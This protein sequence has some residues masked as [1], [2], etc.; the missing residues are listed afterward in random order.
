MDFFNGYNDNKFSCSPRPKRYFEIK[1]CERGEWK[2]FKRYHYLNTEISKA[3][4]CYGLYDKENDE[5]IGFIGILHTPHPVNKKL[6]RVSRLVILPDYQ[7]IGLGFKFLT[8]I[9]KIY[10]NKGYDFEIISS[11]RN[12]IYKLKKDN[13]WIL[14]RIGMMKN[15]KTAKIKW[16]EEKCR[17]NCITASFFY[18]K[19]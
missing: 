14:S 4:K 5:I 18:K 11:A 2:K 6:K 15:S 17:T 9:A 10:T 13:Q 12:L 19:K 3:C 7:G 16:F 8:E 1:E